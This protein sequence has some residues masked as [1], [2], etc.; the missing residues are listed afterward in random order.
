MI[1]VKLTTSSSSNYIL[2]I[3]LDIVF[4]VVF[5]GVGIEPRI[6]HTLYK[7]SASKL[8]NWPLAVFFFL[9]F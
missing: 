3:N 1:N 9:H 6:L 4:L 7:C 8:Y 5:G 2:L